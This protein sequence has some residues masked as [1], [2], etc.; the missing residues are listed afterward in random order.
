ME[1]RVWARACGAARSMYAAR[2]RTARAR[3]SSMERFSGWAVEQWPGAISLVLDL[4]AVA[5][6]PRRPG[7]P[8]LPGPP[9]AA[10]GGA[11]DGDAAASAPLRQRGVLPAL[12][13]LHVISDSERA[14][15]REARAVASGDDA[16]A[17]LTLLLG[18]MALPALRV[19]SLDVALLRPLPH[20]L[21]GLQHLVLRVSGDAVAHAADAQPGHGLF[22]TLAGSLPALRTL[23]IAAVVPCCIPGPVDL[24]SCGQLA[25]L[26]L[27]AIHVEEGMAVP[28][29]CHVAAVL[30]ADAVRALREWTGAVAE[31]EWTGVALQGRVNTLVVRGVRTSNDAL[32]RSGLSVLY[33][34]LHVRRLT[35]LHELRIVLD[36]ASLPLGAEDR[37]ALNID[38]NC[39]RVLRVLEVDIPCTLSMRLA[40]VL[41]VRTMVLR[42][43]TFDGFLWCPTVP[44]DPDLHTTPCVPRWAAIFVRFAAAPTGRDEASLRELICHSFRDATGEAGCGAI[45]AGGEGGAWQGAAPAGFRPG[46]GAPACGCRACMD[47]L[48]RAGVPLAAAQAWQ[49]EGFDRLLAPLCR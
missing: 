18:R 49:R 1:P 12:Q 32:A 11:S 25:A 46:D 23:Y 26:A 22:S 39:L 47:C 8:P 20:A 7:R 38:S 45:S 41:E 3:P 19:L 14:P 28:A 34:A 36:A 48:G 24:A 16:A 29:G 2:A 21:A 13:F 42:A 17:A 10:D 37:V 6:P 9:G 44:L 43:R 31:R 15:E 30:P 40:W 35:A 33:D 5:D 27:A 4:R